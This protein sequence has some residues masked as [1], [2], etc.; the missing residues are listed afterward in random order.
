[1]ELKPGKYIVTK[2]EK[3]TLKRDSY[4]IQ[5]I[6]DPLNNIDGGHE[7]FYFEDA[8][9]AFE[10]GDSVQ[11]TPFVGIRKT[12]YDRRTV[13]KIISAD[14]QVAFCKEYGDVPIKLKTGAPVPARGDVVILGGYD[15]E[16][17]YEI[18]ENLTALRIRQE[19]LLQ[20]T[21][22]H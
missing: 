10:V 13:A 17:R 11:V 22:Q 9:G 3:G 20:H 4:C 5:P 15:D 8:R 6:D 1:M 12:S 21:K 14:G 19:F 18:I 2:I 7:F 16:H